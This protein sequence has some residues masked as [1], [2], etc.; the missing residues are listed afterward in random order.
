MQRLT[1]AL[2][3][4]AVLLASSAVGLPSA[5]AADGGLLR[6]A[7]LSPD[8]P[9]VDVYVDSVSDPDAGIA[10]RGVGYGA[11]SGYQAVTPGIYT[12]S[13]R[14]AGDAP[15]T[16]P[17]LSTTV[18]IRADSARTVAG[19]GPFSDL[20]LTVLDDALTPPPAG[21]A[22]MRVIAAASNAAVLDV[23]LTGG[24][25]VASNLRFPQTGDYVD[26]PAGR[27]GLRVT[28]DGAELTELPVDFAAGSI[29]TVLVLDDPAGGLTVRTVLDAAGPGNVPVGAVAAGA[30]GSSTGTASSR[31]VAGGVAALATAGLL[32]TGIHR[33]PRGRRRARHAADS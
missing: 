32:A 21:Q 10:L 6:L 33:L 14:T 8:T 25:P 3:A 19:V 18:D 13:M 1:R 29:Y 24:D 22:R 16:P 20:G 5:A 12:V 31:L 26:V 4:L 7:H 30:G 2:C 9:D 28:P 15:D 17:V 11:V 23:S 27:A